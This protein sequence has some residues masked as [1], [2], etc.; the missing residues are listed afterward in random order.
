MRARMILAMV[1]AAGVIWLWHEGTGGNAVRAQAEPTALEN[2]DMNGD[3][4]RDVSDAIYL[5]NWLFG[6]GPEPVAFAQDGDGLD[7]EQA[8]ILSYFRLSE[9][10]ASPGG[11]PVVTLQISGANLQILNGTGETGMKNGLGNLIIGYNEPGAAAS[12]RSGSHNF[13]VGPRHQYSSFGG[14][15]IGADN[16]ISGEYATV[17]AG[18]GNTASGRFSTVSA[19]FS[20]TASGEYA[21]VSGGCEHTA[22]GTYATVSGGQRNTASG[23]WGTVS[24]GLDREAPADHDWRAGE[25]FEDQ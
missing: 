7:P 22:S 9:D 23:Q 12:D 15:V 4:A 1:L 25:A 3:G 20:N 13:V 14:A 24:G 17:T 6:G 2:G 5:F 16:T 21:A 10:P 8:R 18:S 11:D 19:S